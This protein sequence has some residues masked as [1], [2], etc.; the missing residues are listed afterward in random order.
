VT[1]EGA[2]ELVEKLEHLGGLCHVVGHS[3][4]LILYVGAG[5]DGLPLGCLG[6]EVGTEEYSITGSG[7][8]CVGVASPVCVDVDHEL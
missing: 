5:D 6:D 8:T 2:V 7:S 1:L 4:I 3:A